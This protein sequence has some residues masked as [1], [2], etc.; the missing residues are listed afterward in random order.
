MLPIERLS[1]TE[2]LRMME[3]LWTDL[4]REESAL[5][6]PAWHGSAL[7]EAEAALDAGQANFIDWDQAKKTLLGDSKT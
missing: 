7:R 4:S 3:A 5:A 2:K 1:R 6:S